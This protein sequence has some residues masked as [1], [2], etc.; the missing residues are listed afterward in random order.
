MENKFRALKNGLDGT[1]IDFGLKQE[2]PTRGLILEILDFVDDVV[3]ALGS[4]E[5]IRQLRR[6]ATEGD[7]GADRQLAAFART[8]DLRAV[9]DLLVDETKRGL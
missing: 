1:L 9:V 3:D 7:T 4:R 2:A 6:W 8:G 5:E